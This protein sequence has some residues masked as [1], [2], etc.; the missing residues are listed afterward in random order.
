[1][2]WFRSSR[3]R[4]VTPSLLASGWVSGLSGPFLLGLGTS[5]V[6]GL[7]PL[8]FFCPG[9]FP[10]L[11]PNLFR[12]RDHYLFAHSLPQVICCHH[13]ACPWCVPMW[14]ERWNSLV[15]LMRTSYWLHL[16]LIISVK[17]HLSIQSHSGVRASAH[18]LGHTI[19]S[20]LWGPIASTCQGLALGQA[21]LQGRS[22]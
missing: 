14:R 5:G 8:P 11:S 7:N 1:M 18:E 20:I 15:S 10:C 13:K 21:L 2:L 17:A 22:C 16:T 9:F 4:S 19:Q 3:P 12:V 6:T